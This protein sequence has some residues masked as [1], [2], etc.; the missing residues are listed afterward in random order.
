MRALIL[1]K[2]KLHYQTDYPVPHPRKD[3]ALIKVT[4]AGICNT[5]FEITK[6]YIKFQ[7]ILGHEF[8]GIVE[9]CN[10]KNLIG[11]R[12]VGEINI[13]CGACSYCKKKMQNHCPVRSVLGI[14][15]K[16]G[17]FSEY[18]TLPVKNLHLVPDSV[19]DEEAVFVEPLAAAF[20]ITRQVDIMPYGKVCVLGDGKLGLL[21]GQVLS[22]TNCDLVVVGKHKDK[23]SILKRRGIKTALVS[24][25]NKREFDVVV[26]C[27]GSSSGM[28]TALKIVKPQ[29][30]IIIKTTI[31]EKRAV[32]LNRVVV[33]EL[34]LIGSRCGPFPPAIKAIETKKVD[35]H[36]LISKTFSL[37]DGIKA[38][39]YALRK[40]V[41]KVI[42]EIA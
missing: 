14:L 35:V 13:G 15:N 28:E 27:T 32:D 23:L 17:V 41:L 25:F 31:A 19:S 2:N 21:V 34:A 3:E 39:K 36:P 6:G 37:E 4:H 40:G 5:D 11:K 29:G 26:D 1:K 16:D 18:I 30:K 8:V 20:E 9:K 33:N 42:V 10:V 22:L 24:N 7:G 38:F 12:V